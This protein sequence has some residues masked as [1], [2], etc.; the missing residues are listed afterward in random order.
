VRAG[1]RWR[2]WRCGPCGS[3]R[4]CARGPAKPRNGGEG[5]WGMGRWCRSRSTAEVVA[6]STSSATREA[7]AP[8]RYSRWGDTCATTLEYSFKV[9][10]I[11]Q[12]IWNTGSISTQIYWLQKMKLSLCK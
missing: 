12:R 3:R 2:W 8:R 5:G 6:D 4:H 7:A 9:H 11:D 10:G 1:R